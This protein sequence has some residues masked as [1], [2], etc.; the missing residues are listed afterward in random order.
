MVS[1]DSLITGS[2]ANLRELR[3]DPRFRQLVDSIEE[4]LHDEYREKDGEDVQERLQVHAA[5]QS[6]PGEADGDG[7]AHL[8]RVEKM[9][10]VPVREP[11]HGEQLFHGSCAVSGIAAD[12]KVKSVSG[13]VTL[14]GQMPQGGAQVLADRQHVDLVGA[15]PGGQP[16]LVRQILR[17]FPD[18]P[19]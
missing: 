11:A 5:A 18:H 17:W 6:C 8:G 3:Q 12:T 9:A 14:D 2:E 7:E 10:G 4:K 16:G 1:V 19:L 13:N 15:Q